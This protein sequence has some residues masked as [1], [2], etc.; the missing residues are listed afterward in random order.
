MKW[1]NANICSTKA[2]LEQAPKVFK[3]VSVNA[4]FGVALRMVN[5]F[6]L[7]C[8]TKFVVGFKRVGE[9]IRSLF[10]VLANIRVKLLAIRA[11]NM[12]QT[13]L[14]GLRFR[15]ALQNALH[16][17]QVPLTRTLRSATRS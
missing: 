11:R 16:R 8:V 13:D 17:L 12:E 3:S 15:C 14:R 6:V 10:D 1:F 4:I 9:N 5:N 2:A 7:I